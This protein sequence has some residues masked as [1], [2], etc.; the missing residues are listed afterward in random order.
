MKKMFKN[1]PNHAVLLLAL[2]LCLISGI[3]SHMILTSFGSVE[4]EN[5]SVVTD[6]GTIRGY[7]LVPDG[8][9]SENPAP[10]IVVSHGASSSAESVESWYIELARRGYVVFAPNMY[11]HG[12]S[13]IADAAYD[14]TIAY[15]S[16]GLYD[17]VEYL[18]TLNFV[19]SEKVAVMGHSLG[20]GSSI[21]VAEYYTSLEREALENGATKEEAHELNKLAACLPV[22]YPLEVFIESL[23][24]MSSPE[25]N[26]FNCD[27][28]CILGKADD[29]QS[30]LQKDVLTNEYGVRWLQVQTGIVADKVE[31]GH[32]YTNEENGYTFRLWNPNEI[33]NQNFI[34]T[35]TASYVIDFFEDIWGA[36]N[37]IESSN[38]IWYWKQLFSFIGIIGFFLFVVPCLYFVLKMPVFNTL[39][40]ENTFVLPPLLGDARKKYLKSIIRG[41]LINTITFLPVVLIGMMG[42]NNAVFPQS[43]TSGFAA[44]GIACGISTL[45][46]V[47]K[48]TGLKYKENAEYFGFKTTWKE[49]GKLVALSATVTGLTFGVLFMVK[50]I[51]NTDFR[52]W[53][54]AIRPFAANKL[55]IALRYLPMFFILQF[56][57]GIAIRRNNFDNWSDK[58]RIA[59]STTMALIPIVIMLAITY[60]PILF[61][62]SPLFGMD[63]S[64]LILLSAGQSAIKLYSYIISVGITAFIHVKAQ[65]YTGNIWAGALINSMIICIITVANCNSITAF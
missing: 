11:G 26:G 50:Y 3:G 24:S 40:R 2:I 32:I 46:A 25:F 27:L 30:W 5:V 36:P 34:S 7:L 13:S 61:I 52:L 28:G 49:F 18:H 14:G 16:N 56:A 45:L 37:K 39:E 58:K 10:G 9:N 57:N 51:F 62:G 54:Y 4:V 64:N 35:K 42:I 15:E 47:R 17:S 59:F 12:D 8:V 38:Q 29:F 63:G 48:G 21:K 22:G 65:K 19:D 41:V 20:G 31:E 1:K 23:P 33:H 6:L 43:S 53:T 55:T 44:W 60:V